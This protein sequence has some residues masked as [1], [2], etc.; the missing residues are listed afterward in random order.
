VTVETCRVQ[1]HERFIPTLEQLRSNQFNTVCRPMRRAACRNAKFSSYSFET[2]GI[3]FCDGR[4]SSNTINCSS[5]LNKHNAVLR[6]FEINYKFVNIRSNA[7]VRSNR[8]GSTAAIY[9]LFMSNYLMVSYLLTAI[10]SRQR[11]KNYTAASLLDGLCFAIAVV[12]QFSKLG[13]ITITSHC[14]WPI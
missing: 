4:C 11:I 14:R 7:V 8:P 9:R 13:S 6:K 2:P 12:K 10:F 5:G 1:R 3:T